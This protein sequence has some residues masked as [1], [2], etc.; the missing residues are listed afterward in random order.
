L[1]NFG[2]SFIEIQALLICVRCRKFVVIFKNV[3]INLLISY[4]LGVQS[5]TTKVGGKPS[6]LVCLRQ[7][8]I[9]VHLRDHAT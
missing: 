6:L 1:I 3:A 7:R 9:T 2:I 4:D 5:V 8:H